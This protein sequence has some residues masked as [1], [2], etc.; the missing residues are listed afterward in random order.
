MTD[1]S[2]PIKLLFLLTHIQLPHKACH[3]IVLEVFGKNF[4]CKS[5]FIQ[6][7]KTLAILKKMENISVKILQQQ[8]T[9]MNLKTWQSFRNTSDHFVPVSSKRNKMKLSS[10]FQLSSKLQ[11][12]ILMSISKVRSISQNKK[13][14]RLYG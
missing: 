5:L 3:V 11:S 9:H 14:I 12:S 7:Q 10:K 1:D 13:C 8:V 6:N 4:F 2:T